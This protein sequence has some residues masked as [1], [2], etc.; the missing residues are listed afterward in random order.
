MYK[1]GI[2]ILLALAMV[3]MLGA[4]GSKEETRSFELDQNGV[5][6]TMKYYYE[7]DTVT[8]QTTK[9]VLPYESIGITTKEEAKEIL[10]PLSAELQGVEGLTQKI[11]YGDT[12]AT[13]TLEVD[14]EKLDFDEANGLP[15]MMVE[16]DSDG[17]ISMEKSADML[18]DQGFK[19]K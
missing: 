1:K 2:G 14:Y 16:G 5:L 18:L 11:E 3:F 7:G 9:N 13:E 19:E 15:G 17:K 10:D 8:K 4:C 12:E 6:I